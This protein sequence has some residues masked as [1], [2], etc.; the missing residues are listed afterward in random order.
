MKLGKWE[1]P[2]PTG[3]GG[4]GSEGGGEGW[5]GKDGP[6][7]METWVWAWK[8]GRWHDQAILAVHGAR[9]TKAGVHAVRPGLSVD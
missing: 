2:Q 7:A 8:G 6:E 1:E 3:G 5:E 9:G 4:W